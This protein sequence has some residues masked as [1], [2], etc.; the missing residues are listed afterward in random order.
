MPAPVSLPLH[1]PLHGH[2]EPHTTAGRYVREMVFAASDGLVTTFAVVAGAAGA[3]LSYVVIIILGFANLIADGISMG[4]GE[5]LGS[6]SEQ[7]FFRAQAKH[8]AWEVEH[9]PEA[10]EAEIREIFMNWGFR[11][12]DL[13]RAIAVVKSD[14]KVWVDIMMKFELDLEDGSGKLPIKRGMV[15]FSSFVVIGVAP[16]LAFVFGLP[17]AFTVSIILTALVMFTVGALRSKFTRAHWWQSGFEMLLVG[18]V[19]AASAYGIGVVLS[20]IFHI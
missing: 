1:H 17:G 13:E 18:S 12:E 19:A 7:Q 15:M 20:S 8:E 16:L 11:G 9:M 5:Y 2:V 10:E 4:L 6:K 14:P 3:D